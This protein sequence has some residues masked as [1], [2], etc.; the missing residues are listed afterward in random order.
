MFHRIVIAAALAL[1]LSGCIT[2][3]EYGADA[4]SDD[5]YYSEPS[6]D[7]YDYAYDNYGPY[8]DRYY[9]P[10]YDRFGYRRYG[11][12]WSSSIGYSFG[13]GAFGR[14]GF[15]YWYFGY[16]YGYGHGYPYNQHRP[17]RY[18]GHGNNNDRHRP[19]QHRPPHQ[20]PPGEL[21]PP[22]NTRPPGERR[23]PRLVER[24][25]VPGRRLQDL[26]RPVQDVST[27]PRILNGSMPRVR[28]MR[29]EPSEPSPR[30]VL[31][32]P[33]PPQGGYEPRAEAPPPPRPAPMPPRRFEQS[34]DSPEFR[35][36]PAPRQRPEASEREARPEPE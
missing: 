36:A 19:P 23:P 18:Y 17:Y 9:D 10:Y 20:R 33:S 13:D 30:A 27:A 7:R 3:Y 25:D 21:D 16:G 32:R 11:G 5:Y 26:G 31:A 12:G 2:V 29:P 35:P 6:V 34:Q 4:E 15:P 14:Y 22:P 8:Y 28:P 24:E 1:G